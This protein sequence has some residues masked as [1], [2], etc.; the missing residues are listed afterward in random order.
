VGPRAV[1]D[2]V[3]KRKIPSPRRESNP[4]TPDR[5]ARSLVLYR[6]SYHVRMTEND[7]LG[8]EGD[9]GL[10]KGTV[11]ERNHGKPV[12]IVGHWRR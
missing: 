6:L 9:R 3:V 8:E 1:L 4:R 12:K 7:K 11:S 5:L 10:F 2:A